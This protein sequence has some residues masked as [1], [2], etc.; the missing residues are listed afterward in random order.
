MFPI[1]L[2]LSILPVI[3]VGNGPLAARRLALLDEDRARSVT[4]YA[5]APSEALVRA[6]GPRLLRR[7]PTPA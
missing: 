2:D 4:S 7:W 1:M 6:A 5:P 3:L